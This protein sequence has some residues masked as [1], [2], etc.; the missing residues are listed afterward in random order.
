MKMRDGES[1]H[2]YLM[3]CALSHDTTMARAFLRAL[4]APV[5]KVY[6]RIDII[7][8]VDKYTDIGACRKQRYGV[9]M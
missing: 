4:G 2:D 8:K 5:P 7:A 9:R 3:R 1:W 6:P